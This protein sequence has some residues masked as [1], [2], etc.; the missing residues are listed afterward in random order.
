MSSA[1]A[2][3]FVGID[4]GTTGAKVAL[5][6]GRGNELG[7]GYCD[8]PCVHPHPGWV[9]QNVEDVWRGICQASRIA[10]TRANVPDPA[11]RSIGLSSQRGSFVLL[12]E[13]EQPLAPSVLWND[14]RAK[15][16]EAVFAERI[17]LDRYRRITGMPI[18]GS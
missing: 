11:L 17:G 14:S 4:A 16:M 1:T 12:D 9:E 13:R 5:F 6:D 7:S 10:R 18:S 15:D 2:D 3:V 8:Y